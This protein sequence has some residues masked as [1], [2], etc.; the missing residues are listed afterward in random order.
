MHLTLPYM[1]TKC[2]RSLLDTLNEIYSTVVVKDVLTV[3][4]SF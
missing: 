2:S 3:G 1:F 4:G